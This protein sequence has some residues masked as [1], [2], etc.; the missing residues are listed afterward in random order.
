MDREQKGYLILL[1]LFSPILGLFKL[2]K[3]KN[4][5]DITFFGTF[6]FGL[7]GSVF[8]Y[9]VGTDGHSHLMKAKEFYLDMSL[10]EFFKK[11]YEILTF[12]STEG[13]TDIYLHCISFISASL[14][15]TPELI[16]VFAGLV[17]GYFFT[18]SVLL[19]LKNNLDIKKTYILVGFIILL[20]IIRSIGALNSI[21]MWTGMWVLF[22]GTY[23][24]ATTKKRKYILVILFSVLVH[25]SYALILL[26]VTAAYI[27]Q[28][29][30]KILV[31]LYIVSFFTTVG[32]SFVKAYIPQS[33]L[34]EKKQN[35]YAVDSDQDVKRYEKNSIN[36]KKESE[37]SNFYK[38][39]GETNYLN[40]SI[41]GLSIILIFF[42]LKKESDRNLIF[43]VA[44]GIGVYAFSN[45]VAFSP[46]LQGR[47][48]MIAATFILAA[49]IHLQLTLKKYNLKIKSIKR[50]NT[51]LLFFLISSIPMFLF[52]LSY[53]LQSFSFF[54][55]FLPQVSWLLGDGDYSIRGVIGLFI[56]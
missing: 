54:L 35:T 28:K 56:D 21:R 4:E 40:Y 45:L 5:K 30:K 23:S 25:F 39:S 2:L 12:N 16:H 7:V 20:L 46:S 33:D 38:A 44:V 1:F 29:N 31:A 51:A 13:S 36:A 9:I 52:Q 6:F 3:L 53:I 55:L 11:S 41:V 19:I 27:L 18:K 43:L 50:L 8:V 48:K 26:P 42:Y 15:Q 17:F 10:V 22:Y 14:L 32:F 37:N 47:T 24:W 49:A 34:I